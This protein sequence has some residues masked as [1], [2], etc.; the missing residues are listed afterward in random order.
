MRFFQKNYVYIINIHT[1]IYIY[2]YISK[3]TLYIY[4]YI[5]NCYFFMVFAP[6]TFYPAATFHPRSARRWRDWWLRRWQ[7][8]QILRPRS[9]WGFIAIDL[10]VLYVDLPIG[11]MYGIYAKWWLMVINGH[12]IVIN[13]DLMMIDGDWIVINVDLMMIDGDE[14]WLNCD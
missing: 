6:V 10:M 5:Y 8:W 2:I 1:Y 12:W 9:W 13:V 3:E 11:S 14:W 7:T 4:I